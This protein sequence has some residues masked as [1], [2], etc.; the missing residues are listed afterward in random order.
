MDVCLEV[1]D[2]AAHVAQPGV[3]EKLCRA[4]KGCTHFSMFKGL[5]NCRLQTDCPV[6]GRYKV[7]PRTALGTTWK[8]RENG[9]EYCES[10]KLSKAQCEASKCCHWN[11]WEHGSA[12]NWG[13]GK[14]W[15]S[16]ERRV[17][18]DLK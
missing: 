4:T 10:G 13:R 7:T 18:T 11:T 9:E 6:A 5:T 2:L 3:V 8:L 14:C 1:H 16:I 15:S 17:C 12:S